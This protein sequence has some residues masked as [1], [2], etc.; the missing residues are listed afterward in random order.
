MTGRLSIWLCAF[1]VGVLA[2]LALALMPSPPHV[3]NTGWDKLNHLLAFSVMTWLG[4][5]AFPQHLA[6]LL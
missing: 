1:S 4:C 2:V 3:P 6:I 5:K